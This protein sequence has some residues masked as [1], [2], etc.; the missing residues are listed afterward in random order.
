MMYKKL[1]RTMAILL[2]SGMVFADA[3]MFVNAD[4]N[5]SEQMI[6]D[7]CIV[8]DT[9]SSVFDDELAVLY[10]EN[11]EIF[12][13]EYI[14]YLSEQSVP[15]QTIAE[16]DIVPLTLHQGVS[17]Q[18]TVSG[19]VNTYSF[20]STESAAQRC[21]IQIVVRDVPDNLDPV[22]KIT[23]NDTGETITMDKNEE[24]EREEYRSG[25]F[26]L[27]GGDY[28]VTVE[29]KNGN[30]NLTE[31]YKIIYTWDYDITYCTNV[32]MKSFSITSTSKYKVNKTVDFDVSL[33]E[34][35]SRADLPLDAE[36]ATVRISSNVST[37]SGCTYGGVSGAIRFNASGK[38]YPELENNV[39]YNME[40]DEHETVRQTAVISSTVKQMSSGVINITV[41]LYFQYRNKNYV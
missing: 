13:M 10:E 18:I 24:G 9:I 40:A 7:G 25:L 2:A 15:A 21:G 11:P 8:E 26:E 19:E 20:T 29:D 22:I 38:N 28:T 3:A 16:D 32:P 39:V 12:D 1:K 37:S 5:L 34:Y 4:E 35:I 6:N 23:Y 31:S 17:D 30:V 41:K 14:K 36:M 33:K 27:H